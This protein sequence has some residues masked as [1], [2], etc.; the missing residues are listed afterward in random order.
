M[1]RYA[2]QEDVRRI[3]ELICTLEERELDYLGFCSAY[4]E[5]QDDGRHIAF[6]W[7][8]GAAHSDR[9]LALLNMRMEQQLHHA[10][11][12]AEVQELVVSPKLRGQGVGKQLL[13]RAVDEARRAGCLRL[14][15]VTNQRRLGAHRFYEREGMAQTHY[16]YTMDL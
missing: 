6:V 4:A 2:T 8:D 14:E 7:T 12:I 1:I 13:D 10:G 16:G 15:L 9:I 3:W 5:Q 11:R